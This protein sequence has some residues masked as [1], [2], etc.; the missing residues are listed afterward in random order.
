MAINI[1]LN[2]S[3][4]IWAGW[5]I[6]F[7][8]DFF[9]IV[10]DRAPQSIDTAI[11]DL[12]MI[13]LDRAAGYFD[14]A[15]VDEWRAAGRHLVTIPQIAASDLHESLKHGAVTLV[16]VRNTN[17]WNEARIDGARHIP[18]GY[19]AE[20]IAEIPKTR[21]IVVQCAAGARSSI[22]ASILQA[23]GV[24]NVINLT[25]GIGDWIRNGYPTN[26]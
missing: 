15:V 8:A 5:L 23:N 12:A 19:L 20:R 4:K 11:R 21:P 10:D 14:A 7:D 22:G 2:A 3:F 25:G 16:D 26:N 17:E 1:P 13:G 6:P 9:L 24:E 18:L